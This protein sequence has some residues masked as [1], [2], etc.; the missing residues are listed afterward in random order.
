MSIN[1]F[2]SFQS[3]ATQFL[4]L[5][6]QHTEVLALYLPALGKGMLPEFVLLNS[7]KPKALPQFLQL[8]SYC[9]YMAFLPSVP[10]QM[11][12]VL[13]HSSFKFNITNQ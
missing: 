10:D 9:E 12:C 2:I 13:F 7:Q 8:P 4:P 6:M 1:I 11:L 5:S 3:M